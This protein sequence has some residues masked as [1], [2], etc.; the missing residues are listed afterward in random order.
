MA[1]YTFRGLNFG[2]SSASSHTI[3]IKMNKTVAFHLSSTLMTVIHLNIFTCC[4]SLKITKQYLRLECPSTVHLNHF[5]A[6]TLLD[7]RFCTSLNSSVHG[8]WV[9]GQGSSN[10]DESVVTVSFLT[11]SRAWQKYLFKRHHNCSLPVYWMGAKSQRWLFLS[12]SRLGI[13]NHYSI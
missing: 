12:R 6:S 8:F 13:R 3:K 9:V 1:S 5:T 11:P 2:N 7:A 10:S 4:V